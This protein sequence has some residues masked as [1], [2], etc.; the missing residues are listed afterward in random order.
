MPSAAPM[1]PS[2][3]IPSGTPWFPVGGAGYPPVAGAPYTRHAVDMLLSGLNRYRVFVVLTGILYLTSG[4]VAFLLGYSQFAGSPT[5]SLSIPCPGTNTTAPPP[6]PSNPLFSPQVGG[7]VALEAV[8]AIAAFIFLILAFVQW[9]RGVHTLATFSYELGGAHGASAQ[10]AEQDYSITIWA[11]V[12]WLLAIVGVAV[13]AVVLVTG[14]ITSQL[15]S[16]NCMGSVSLASLQP[17]LVAISVTSTVVTT[18]MYFLMHFF[19]SR[20][21]RN[22]LYESSRPDM[23]L[24]LDRARRTIVLGPPFLLLGLLSVWVPLL[25]SLQVVAAV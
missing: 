5:S 6:I 17:T 2:G 3:P 12:G 21:Y 4:G 11:F 9:R 1:P 10:R 16:P 15:L 25:Q 13:A 7:L 14:Q 18:S 19:A 20:S 8:S 22:A 23:Q 24:A